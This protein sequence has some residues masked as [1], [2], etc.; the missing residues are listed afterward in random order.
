MHQTKNVQEKKWKSWKTGKSISEPWTRMHSH[1]VLNDAVADIFADWELYPT[2]FWYNFQAVA[3]FPFVPCNVS[4]ELPLR[5]KCPN[6]EFFW[7]R[8]FLHSDWIR[9]DTEYGEILRISPYSVR[10]KE[11]TNL[12][13]LRIWTL[14][15]QCTNPEY[16]K[17]INNLGKNSYKQLKI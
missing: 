1:G 5:E 8:I 16:Q 4:L 6:T 9:R 11:N 12:K 10:M 13:K 17:R 2:F 14:F 15:T 7:V 3:Y